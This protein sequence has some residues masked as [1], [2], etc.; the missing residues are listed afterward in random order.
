MTRTARDPLID[1]VR[2]VAMAGV[3]VGHWLVTVVAIGPGGALERLEIQSSLRALPE[4]TP[5][6]WVLQTLGLFFLAGGYAATVSRRRSVDR[7]E[8]FGPWLLTRCRKLAVAVA[9][10]LAAWAIVLGLLAWLAGL[11]WPAADVV[12]NLVTS[13]LW[14]LGVYLVL[15][16]LT[17]LARALHARLGIA[18]VLVPAGL[19]VVVEV[20]VEVGA[21]PAV[22]YLTVLAV[23]WSAWQLGVS[24]AA[25]WRPGWLAGAGLLVVGVAACVVLVLV[26]GYSAA[27]VGGTGARSNLNPPSAFALALAAA[28]IG[29]VLLLARPLRALAVRRGWRTAVAWVNDRA[30]PIF[31]LHQS[32]LTT[33]VL[34]GAVFGALPGLHEPPEGL[35]WPLAR[36]AWYPAFAAVLVMLLLCLQQLLA[37]RRA[38]V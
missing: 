7:G 32:A 13:P 12:I 29:V 16:A 18:G 19:A 1:V 27:A 2:A 15:L 38:R 10:V 8:R 14:F 6:S 34:L 21:P 25:G 11:Q 23:W 33:V 17:P 37:L 9:V 3:V 4:L 31:L 22:G 35:A 28:Q 26:A 24:L 5:L 30:L 20:A 36:L